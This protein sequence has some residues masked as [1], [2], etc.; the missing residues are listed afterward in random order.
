MPACLSIPVPSL[1]LSP[2]GRKPWKFSFERC[3][4]ASCQVRALLHEELLQSLKTGLVGRVTFQD[5]DGQ[6]ITVDFSLK[7]FTAALSELP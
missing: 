4:P 2:V 7:G 5:A 3:D 1:H 6:P